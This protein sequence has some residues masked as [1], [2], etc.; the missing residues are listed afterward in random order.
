[1]RFKGETGWKRR[2]E[3]ITVAT[4]RAEATQIRKT[5]LWRRV[6]IGS[7]R[8]KDTR[9]RQTDRERERGREKR[10]KFK[11]KKVQEKKKSKK[12]EAKMNFS[13]NKIKTYAV[14]T[15]ISMRTPPL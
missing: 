13:K 9:E 1:M 8:K 3:L 15:P 14:F 5:A 4:R 11:R 12:R 7:R 6:G 2:G 10:K